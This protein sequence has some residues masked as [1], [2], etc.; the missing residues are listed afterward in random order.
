MSHEIVLRNYF[1]A[2][3]ENRPHILASVF[4]SDASLQVR[5]NSTN[6]AFPD[7]AQ[8]REAI[9]EV[10]I[11]QFNRTYENIYS[12]YLARPPATA[13][14]F[15]CGWLVGMTDKESKSVR[16]GCGTYKWTFNQ[17]AQGLASALVISIEVM[18]VLPPN[19]TAA[20]LPWLLRLSY[21][22]CSPM[23]ALEMAPSL[24]EL[25]PVLECLAGK[26]IG[27]SQVAPSK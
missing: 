10:L 16:V 8:G 3:D 6:V 2:K 19:R 26:G 20:V 22:W 1:H 27:A 21:P 15:A 25:A 18:L 14:S 23:Q 9:A 12:F 7:K 13:Q 24:G 17:E 4:T 11:G 5:N